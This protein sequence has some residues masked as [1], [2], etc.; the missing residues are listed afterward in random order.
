[1]W[2]GIGGLCTHAMFGLAP[3]GSPDADHATARTIDLCMIDLC[4]TDM[5]TPE[6]LA[7]REQ[8]ELPDG[9]ATELPG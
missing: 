8:A 6:G 7:L 1:L 4:M 5:L 2:A 3:M 9:I